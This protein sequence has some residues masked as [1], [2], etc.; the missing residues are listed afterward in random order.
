MRKIQPQNSQSLFN[1]ASMLEAENV[2]QKNQLFLNKVSHELRT[3]LSVIKMYV[4][5]IED[6]MYE[7]NKIVFQ[8]LR[9][10]F[11]EFEMLIDDMVKEEK[12]NK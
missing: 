1:S 8:S 7:N 12:E 2:D 9:G 4:E 10:K 5:S 6:G 11:K 3:P